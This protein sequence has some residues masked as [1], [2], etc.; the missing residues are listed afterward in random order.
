[1]QWAVLSPSASTSEELDGA[2]A[3]PGCL[4]TQHCGLSGGFLAGQGG[5][6]LLWGGGNHSSCNH[7]SGNHPG[8][9]LVLPAPTQCGLSRAGGHRAHAV[10]LSLTQQSLGCS[11][12]SPVSILPLWSISPTPPAAANSSALLTWSQPGVIFLKEL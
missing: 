4:Q 2:V 5:C 1:M 3:Q 8:T 9:C 7:G 11:S 6:D 12:C 10:G